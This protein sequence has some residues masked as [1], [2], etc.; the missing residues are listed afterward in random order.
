[1]PEVSGQGEDGKRVEVRGREKGKVGDVIVSVGLVIT[2]GG[3]V[4][5]V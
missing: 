2:V 4:Q 5:K 3:F 1:M